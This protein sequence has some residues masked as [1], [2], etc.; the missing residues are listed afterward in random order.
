MRTV[1]KIGILSKIAFWKIASGN[2]TEFRLLAF[3][4]RKRL[5]SR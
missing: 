4:F 3:T 5:I 1:K 2:G